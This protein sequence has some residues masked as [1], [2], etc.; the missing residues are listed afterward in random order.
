[1]RE[2]THKLYLSLLPLSPVVIVEIPQRKYT[3]LIH[4]CVVLPLHTI[5]LI[6]TE[7]AKLKLY[8]LCRFIGLLCMYPFQI[9]KQIF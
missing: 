7:P 6:L 3:F 2:T 8:K 4:V 9:V 5:V 1:M